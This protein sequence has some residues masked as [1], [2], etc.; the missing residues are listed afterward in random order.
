VRDHPRTGE[1]AFFNN[2]VSR[3]LNALNNDTLLPPHLNIEGQY[4]PSVLVS[5]PELLLPNAVIIR[6]DFVIRV[7]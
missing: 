5:D 3:F 4:Q 7:R 2:A 1:P 6:A